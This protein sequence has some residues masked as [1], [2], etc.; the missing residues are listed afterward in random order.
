MDFQ[1]RLEIVAPVLANWWEFGDQKNP[2]IICTTPKEGHS[3]IPDTDDLT[4]FWT[5]TNFVILRTMAR[6][7]AYAYHGQAVPFHY[8]YFG[9]SAMVC[10]L[11]ASAEYVDKETVWAHEHLHSLEE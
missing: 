6:I 2:C 4:R 3:A 1:S 8:V 11:G 7:Y 5:D 9:S 10:A